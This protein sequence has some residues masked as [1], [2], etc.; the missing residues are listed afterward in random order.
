M[1]K[2][3]LA[4]LLPCL[5]T[6]ALARTW[7]TMAIVDLKELPASRQ[8]VDILSQLAIEYIE[9]GMDEEGNYLFCSYQSRIG[10]IDGEEGEA[11][12]R[13]DFSAAG[14]EGFCEVRG[15]WELYDQLST[16]THVK[17]DGLYTEM[18]ELEERP[19]EKQP[20]F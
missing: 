13:L 1:K 20:S 5:L 3:L 12:L 15:I 14:D 2:I 4:F 16:V 10:F 11:H 18:G 6:P 9:D 17:L 19:Q 8:L 7:T